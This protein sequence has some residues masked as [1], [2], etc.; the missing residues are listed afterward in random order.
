MR[1][2]RFA[3]LSILLAVALAAA[4]AATAAFGVF[5]PRGAKRTATHGGGGVESSTATDTASA[6]G[7]DYSA[8]DFTDVPDDWE[9]IE[10]C[11]TTNTRTTFFD[12]EMSVFHSATTGGNAANY[13][14]AAY[15]IAADRTYRD[16]TFEMTFRMVSWT[17]TSRFIAVM[18][19]TQTVDNRLIGYM[20]NYRVKGENAVSSLNKTSA[21]DSNSKIVK[22]I[23]DKKLHTMRIE[24]VGTRCLY[25]MDGILLHDWDVSIKDAHLGGA[26]DSGGFAL[27]V[28]RSQMQIASVKISEPAAEQTASIDDR[29]IASTYYDNG[30]IVNGPTVACD[31]TDGATLDAALTADAR[32]SNAI[33]RYGAD[34]NVVGANGEIL[35]AFDD[36]YLAMRGRIVPVVRVESVAAADAFVEYMSTTRNILDISVLSSDP[37]LVKRVRTACPAMRGMIAYDEPRALSALVAEVHAN[38]A[39]AAVLPQRL[40]TVEAVTYIQARFE[41]V[42]VEPESALYA[43]IC[44]SVNSGA[45]GVVSPYFRDVYDALATYETGSVTR[46]AM[47]VAHRGCSNLTYENSLGAVRLAVENGATHLE[48]DGKLTSDGHI[49]ILHDDDLT[50]STTGTGNVESK[51][52]AELMRYDLTV[53]DA[54]GVKDAYLKDDDG[55]DIIE[56]IPTLEQVLD[57]I[58][59]TDVVL[60]FEIKTDK[61]AIVDKLKSTLTQRGM[62]AQTVAIT[63]DDSGAM[64]DKMKAVLPEM[65]VARLEGLGGSPLSVDD[66]AEILEL[67]GRGN[68]AL[69]KSYSHG[70]GS[71]ALNRYLRD[72][73]MVGWYW[74]FAD[75]S[76]V[77]VGESLGY[78][79]I[80]NNCAETY[81]RRERFVSGAAN[82]SFARLALGDAVSV[83]VTDYSGDVQ[84]RDGSVVYCRRTT[85]G[86]RVIARVQTDRGYMYTQSFAVEKSA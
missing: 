46:T 60:V 62:L 13:Y 7:G 51:T 16:F 1:I 53:R 31:I 76:A 71:L 56:K 55:N 5:A 74:T 23:S 52:L 82:Q 45:Y 37:A 11:D 36:V 39:T 26:L 70:G 12:G 29:L 19:H 17:D 84:T 49:V 78:L 73:G 54:N 4:V 86:W 64:L 42:W 67:L 34:G 3:V 77:R 75:E 8:S 25:Y 63:F 58:E 41:T 83:R 21:N 44:D 65:P 35:G 20:V 27:L 2:K 81:A 43:D 68:A 72:R 50:A 66:F 48:L 80:T 59:N 18:F 28:N 10:K 85:R 61:T 33:L 15:K 79:G 32:P 30:G 24:L 40:A 47:N 22:D 6:A 57:E 69:D 38:L 9:L 14:G